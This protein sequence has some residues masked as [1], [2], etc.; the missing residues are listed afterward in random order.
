MLNSKNEV[1]N[2]AVGHLGNYP[3]VN[4]IDTPKTDIERAFARWYDTVLDLCL[5]LTMPNFALDRAI[6]AQDAKAPAFGYA[7]RY[8]KPANCLKVLGIGNV[9]DKQ[10]NNAVEGDYILSD[11]DYPE[12]MPVRFVKRITTVSKFTP[13]FTMMFSKFLAAYTCLEIT[14]DKSLAKKLMDELPT[15]M[16]VSS[17]LNAQENVPIR[18]SRS[19]FKGARY[20]DNPDYTSKK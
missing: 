14:Q 10:N 4:D 11:E 16:S 8:A 9:L 20:T 15:E 7:Y 13:D 3:S 1:C 17:G 5:K 19:R 12:G 18:I 2:L 6:A